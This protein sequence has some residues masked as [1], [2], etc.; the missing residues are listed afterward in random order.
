MKYIIIAIIGFFVI[1]F[2]VLLFTRGGN[3]SPTSTSTKAVQLSDYAKKS[4]SKA[5]FITDGPINGE[6]AHRVIRID[7]TANSR[8]I[9][10]IQGYNGNVM[11]SNSYPNTSEAF[12]QFLAAIDREGFTKENKIRGT[13]YTAICPA[14][15]RY[16]FQLSQNTENVKKLWTAS[17]ATGSFGGNRQAVTS[18]F[19]AQIPSY[20][21]LTNGVNFSL[22]N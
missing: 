6:N 16:T 12:G 14:Q 15:F 7:V 11:S 22:I 21:K 13:D 10:I 18:L 19:Q 2:G 9:D 4:G 8:T 17:C 3:Q 1:L 5:E 20:I